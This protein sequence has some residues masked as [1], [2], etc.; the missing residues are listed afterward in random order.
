M[1]RSQHRSSARSHD[2]LGCCMQGLTQP[3]LLSLSVKYTS[4]GCDSSSTPDISKAAEPAAAADINCLLM[5]CCRDSVIVCL[6][7]A[8]NALP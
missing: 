5:D 4:R 7:E 2:S 1:W 3:H 8:R 6:R